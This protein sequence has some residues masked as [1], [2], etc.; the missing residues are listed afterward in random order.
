[1][2]IQFSQSLWQL[3][4]SNLS[5]Q[6]WLDYI[7]FYYSESSTKYV[8][9]RSLW[10]TGHNIMQHNLRASVSLI[11]F[12]VEVTNCASDIFV[13]AT[14]WSF[15]C[16]FNLKFLPRFKTV[17]P[18]ECSFHKVA[19]KDHRDCATQLCA[20]CPSPVHL[21]FRGLKPSVLYWLLKEPS[22]RGQIPWFNCFSYS[23]EFQNTDL[24]CFDL[25]WHEKQ[26][27]FARNYFE[28]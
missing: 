5:S 11:D 6:Y 19:P 24:S 18:E 12:R 1:M 13:W 4:Y 26:Y 7:Q 3:K 25:R 20:T 21:S 8:N 23:K 15:V 9:Q 16:L 28:V 17:V 14:N 27:T 22:T 2:A 10:G